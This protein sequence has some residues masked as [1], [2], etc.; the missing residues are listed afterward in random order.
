MISARQI[1]LGRGA[2]CGGW[3]NP[4]VTDGLVAM[5]DGEWN[6]DGGVHDASAT[7]WK[8]L[9]GNG[10][11][12]A[13]NG[14][15][16]WGDKSWNVESTSGRGLAT[17]NIA[18]PFTDQ[19]I[20]IV[21]HPTG[22]SGWG[23]IMAEWSAMATLVL[24]GA[25]VW[26]VAWGADSGTAVQGYNELA[27][28][29]HRI[30]Y[31]YNDSFDYYIDSNKVWTRSATGGSGGGTCYF[32]NRSD[33]NRGIDAKYYCVRLYN[34]ALSAAELLANEIVDAQRFNLTAS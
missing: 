15:Y 28:H 8:D 20:E 25:A 6:A 11:D 5:W 16:S 23:R 21:I 27:L 17:W 1:F 12:A 24:K 34:R 19:T 32:A 7:T 14:S 31:R 18:G 29:R 2:G 4:Y 26:M 30:V 22:N 33:F 13:L 3:V 10:C 9:T